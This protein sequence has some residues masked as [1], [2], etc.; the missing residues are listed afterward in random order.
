MGAGMLLGDVAVEG[1]V[2]VKKTTS[3]KIT[4]LRWKRV[5]ITNLK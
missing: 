5:K 1:V 2:S 3:M 4:N